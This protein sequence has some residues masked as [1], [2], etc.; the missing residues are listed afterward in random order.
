M[1]LRNL[2][3]KEKTDG[4]VPLLSP[5]SRS[6]LTYIGIGIDRHFFGME[7]VEILTHFTITTKREN[8][9]KL[10]EGGRNKGEGITL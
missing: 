7:V 3:N 8:Q 10:R 6:S 4:S 1:Q 5:H 2:S 9:A